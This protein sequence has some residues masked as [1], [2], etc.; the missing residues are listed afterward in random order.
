MIKYVAG[1]LFSPDLEKVVLIEKQKPEWQK[2]LLNGIGGKIDAGEIPE[3]AMIR[4]FREET[5]VTIANWKHFC[6]IDGPDENVYSVDFFYAIS[7]DYDKV[8]T[9]EKEEVITCNSFFLPGDKVIENLN[10]LVPLALDKIENYSG[11]ITVII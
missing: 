7:A 10:W 1:F 2:G 3:E 5:S 9:M 6:R 4:E 8:K 11:R